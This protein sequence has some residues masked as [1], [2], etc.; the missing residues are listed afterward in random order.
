MLWKNLKR[1]VGL[2][3]KRFVVGWTKSFV[4]IIVEMHLTTKETAIKTIWFETSTIL[5]G[6]TGAF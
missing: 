2:A 6:K 5:C 3:E 1:H 4:T